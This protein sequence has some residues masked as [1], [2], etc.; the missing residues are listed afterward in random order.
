MKLVRNMTNSML[1]GGLALLDSAPALAEQRAVDSIVRVL[2]PFQFALVQEGNS[3][4]LID[5]IRIVAEAVTSTPYGEPLRFPAPLLITVGTSHICP[6]S[7][8][9]CYSNSGTESGSNTRVAGIE[10]F[11]R[12]AHSRT[13]CVMVSGGE[14]LALPNI[15]D[16]LKPLLDAGK[17][18]YIA[19]NAGITPIAD[20]IA[21]YPTQLFVILSLW[22]SSEKHDRLRGPGSYE[23]VERNLAKL[24][25]LGSIGRLL[26][27]LTGEDLSVFD[28]IEDLVAKFRIG[29]VLVTRKL[30][31]GRLDNS[32]PKLAPDFVSKVLDRARPVRP[33]VR[34]IYLDIPEL[35]QRH[36]PRVSRL[37][38]LLGIP[39][40]TDCSAGNWMMHL[41]ADGV[42]FPC[43][44]FE[45]RAEI[46]QRSELQLQ[47]QWE[48]ISAVRVNIDTS[49]ACIGETRIDARG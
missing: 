15:R 18:V 34:Q 35:R 24:N 39:V 13:P 6:F 33:H 42:A 5:A 49:S 11:K 1:R 36:A 46:G 40:R 21:D 31:V 41:D 27:V 14:P 25:Q 26:V 12:I 8:A 30:S 44:T 29:S 22:G 16:L 10:L 38:D 3:A 47:Q 37:H 23:R 43:Y 32:S 19:T 4:A 45:G 9:N 20:V 48:N 7:C 17:V 2:S 28:S